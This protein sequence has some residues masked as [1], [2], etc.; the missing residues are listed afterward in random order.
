LRE[1]LDPDGEERIMLPPDNELL[2]DLCAPRFKMLSSGI[3]SGKVS[4][5][6]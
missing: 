2:A 6:T 1:A 3:P 4:E 5:I